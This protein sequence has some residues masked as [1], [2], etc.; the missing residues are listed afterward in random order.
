M[1]SN[2]GESW[3]KENGIITTSAG[4]ALLS[5]YENHALLLQDI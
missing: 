1:R 5:T 2:K 4:M 3:I